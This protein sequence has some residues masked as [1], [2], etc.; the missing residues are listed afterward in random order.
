MQIVFGLVLP[1]GFQ[2]IRFQMALLLVACG[3]LVTNLNALCRMEMGWI[4]SV[5]FEFL[6]LNVLY[7]LVTPKQK[8]KYNFL[9]PNVAGTVHTDLAANRKFSFSVLCRGIQKRCPQ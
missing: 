7:R 9:K 5:V 1:I 3:R 4:A 6:R 2:S 8:L